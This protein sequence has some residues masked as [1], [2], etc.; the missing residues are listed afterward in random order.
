MF[1]RLAQPT[2]EFS[3]ARKNS[4]LCKPWSSKVYLLQYSLV[5][6]WLIKSPNIQSGDWGSSFS[7]LLNLIESPRLQEL[8]IL[9]PLWG[10]KLLMQ[11]RLSLCLLRGLQANSLMNTLHYW[12]G[13][14][15]VLQ[16]IWVIHNFPLSL[17]FHGCT[18]LSHIHLSLHPWPVSY[19]PWAV[20]WSWL[21][22]QGWSRGSYNHKHAFPSSPAA[23][24]QVG[25][26][27]SAAAPAG[28]E[29]Q[30]QIQPAHFFFV[31]SLRVA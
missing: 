7:E 11:T 16:R 17:L 28:R 2:P 15:C 29:I 27:L 4:L 13:V 5:L 30:V 10:R 18:F 9:L 24:P 31:P 23:P 19:L 22:P 20:R 25:R 8:K 3:Q 12:A 14:R 26:L 6:T 1:W 21:V